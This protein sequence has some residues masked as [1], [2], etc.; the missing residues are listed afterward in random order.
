MTEQA[1]P[2]SS[3]RKLLLG[4]GVAVVAAAAIVVCFVLPAE[5][6]IDPTGI[7]KATGVLK[8]SEPGPSL[9]LQRGMKRTGVLTPSDTPLPPTEGAR[10]RFEVTL[11]PYESIELKYEIPQGQAMVFTWQATAPVHVDMHA[12]PYEGGTALTESYLIEEALQ[13]QS[14]RYV[15]AFT[16]IHGWYWQNRSLADVTVT[17]DASGGIVNA[18]T[19][20]QAGEHPRPFSTPPADAPD[21]APAG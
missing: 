5:Y 8:I 19:F 21:A 14:G 18:R 11:A 7:G 12:H 1:P 16:G 2:T 15:A 13:A 6:G 17:L 9:E 4:G 3:R 20:D 10:D